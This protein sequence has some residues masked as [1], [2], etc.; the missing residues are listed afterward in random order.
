MLFLQLTIT[1]NLCLPILLYH[2]PPSRNVVRGG[3]GG[4]GGYIGI[5]LSV[6]LSVHPCVTPL[7]GRYPSELYATMQTCLFEVSFV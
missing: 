4:G 2:P 5:R 3:G 7:T 1:H 6:C